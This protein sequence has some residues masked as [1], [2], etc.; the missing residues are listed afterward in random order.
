MNWITYGLILTVLC[1]LGCTIADMVS[2]DK[3]NQCVKL[4][5]GYSASIT[6][7]PGTVILIYSVKTANNKS[8]S[9][10][11]FQMFKNACM[12]R[13]VCDVNSICQSTQ[14]LVSYTCVRENRIMKTCQK[15][16]LR[17]KG[18]FIQSSK[19]PS[20]SRYTLCEWKILVPT[21]EYVFL[22][23]HDTMLKSQ[24]SKTC[25][26]GLKVETDAQCEG[27]NFT[28]DIICNNK[29]DSKPQNIVACGN[30]SLK[31]V[32][33][34]YMDSNFRFWI[35]FEVKPLSS[36]NLSYLFDNNLSCRDSEAIVVRW[37]WGSSARSIVKMLQ[38]TS[39]TTTTKQVP[40]TP[41]HPFMETNKTRDKENAIKPAVKTDDFQLIFGIV[42]PLLAI[43]LLILVV[44]IYRRL[45]V[46]KTKAVLAKDAAVQTP[47]TRR[48]EN[49]HRGD[50]NGLG[51]IHDSEN[52]HPTIQEGYSHVADEVPFPEA[53]KMHG[54]YSYSGSAAYAEVEESEADNLKPLADKFKFHIA[55]S[56]PALPGRKS[57]YFSEEGTTKSRGSG[58]R[59]SVS[60]QSDYQKG[61]YEE[62][63]ENFI[64]NTNPSSGPS[65]V[66]TDSGIES[67]ERNGAAT[68]HDPI[69][70][71]SSGPA[72][73]NSTSRNSFS[74]GNTQIDPSDPKYYSIQM[75][76]VRK[77]SRDYSSGR[78]NRNQSPEDDVLVLLDNVIYEP[79][80]HTTE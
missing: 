51:S 42:A 55:R 48:V 45:K 24:N 28:S 13:T 64:I 2:I 23:L 43:I 75:V 7:Q 16:P 70:S 14:L 62:I 79:F 50:P 46:V 19:Y 40:T 58:S 1:Y 5:C 68:Q 49:V 27:V 76:N 3:W 20:M 60:S 56:L 29:D 36:R 57:P 41:G 39:T 33:N 59:A 78:D 35:S 30:V 34:K 31:Q 15:D 12:G 74:R 72:A 9:R 54:G 32:Y 73:T 8:F 47:T 22:R 6:C 65:S 80:Y 17:Q 71:T 44:I 37:P 4:L 21:G 11:A 77:S 25:T 67:E 18:G 26:S 10:R 52:L 63:A 66:G 53:A 69:A 38:T 61:I